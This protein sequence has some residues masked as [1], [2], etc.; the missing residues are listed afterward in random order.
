MP[1][2][3]LAVIGRQLTRAGVAAVLTMQG[4]GAA[5]L[6]LVGRM[7][8]L[9]LDELQR[10]GQIDRALAA[11]R[12]ALYDAPAWWQPMLF[13]RVRDGHLWTDPTISLPAP[14]VPEPGHSC[15]TRTDEREDRPARSRA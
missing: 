2:R 5:S 9:L 11:A 14:V 3:S 8:P 10:D 13:L 12:A 7:L 15:P 6:Q 4:D 1:R